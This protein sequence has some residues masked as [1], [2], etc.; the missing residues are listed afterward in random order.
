MVQRGVGRFAVLQS[1]MD[2]PWTDS[3]LAVVMSSD[4]DNDDGDGEGF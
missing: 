2:N 3:G 1:L 4:E